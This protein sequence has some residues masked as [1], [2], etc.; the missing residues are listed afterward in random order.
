MK[1]ISIFILAL[2]YITTFSG[3]TIKMHYCMGELVGWDFSHSKDQ[4]CSRCGMKASESKGCC[5]D[6]QKVLKLDTAQKISDA[7]FLFPLFTAST[8]LV[9]TSF[10]LIPA[11]V[12]LLVNNH[13]VSNAPPRSCG[14]A[15]YIR[16]C[17]FLI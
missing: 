17:I 2:L 1:R 16:N 10:E 7:S 3:V 15:V 11:S 12:P 8:S 4:N 13:P 9:N 14:I 6:K 5:E